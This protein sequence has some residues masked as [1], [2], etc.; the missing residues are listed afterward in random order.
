MARQRFNPLCRNMGNL[1]LAIRKE[2]C[3]H[4]WPRS[5]KWKSSIASGPAGSLG[6]LCQRPKVFGPS[7][8]D[9]W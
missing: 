8:V 7:T 2:E 1:T 4:T 3:I 9:E 5:V 6:F